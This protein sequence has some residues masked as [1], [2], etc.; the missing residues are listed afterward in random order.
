LVL[1]SF[2]YTVVEAD[3]PAEVWHAWY[4]HRGAI[5]MVLMKASPDGSISEFIT[6]LQ[7]LCPQIRA[8]FVSDGS[9]AELT[10]MPCE[11]TV[12]HKP[13]RPDALAETISGLLHGTMTRAVS[14]LS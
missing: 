10:D 14:S 4:E 6:R 9:S 12:L 11:Y 2:G 8:L 7:L 13:F 5:D 3:S 1:R